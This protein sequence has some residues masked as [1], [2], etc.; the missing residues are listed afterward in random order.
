MNCTIYRRVHC[1]VEAMRRNIYSCF[2]RCY[3]QVK[4]CPP[5]RLDCLGQADRTDPTFVDF[6]PDLWTILD[7]PIWFGR[8]SG[9]GQPVSWVGWVGSDRSVRLVGLVGR[10]DLYPSIVLTKHWNLEIT[11]C[12]KT[13]NIWFSNKCWI[14]KK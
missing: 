2:V 10:R 6:D 5:D 4:V 11:G 1:S 13:G 3:A 7:R 9:S 8:F 12:N 14:I